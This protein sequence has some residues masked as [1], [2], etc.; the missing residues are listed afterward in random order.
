M[1]MHTHTNIVYIIHVYRAIYNEWFF[2]CNLFHLVCVGVGRC[3]CSLITDKDLIV[4]KIMSKGGRDHH[5]ALSQIPRHF[6]VFDVVCDTI[7]YYGLINTCLFWKLLIGSC[8][9]LGQ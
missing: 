2:L 7:S 9:T 8:L 3:D 1:R 6:C 4:D 5:L